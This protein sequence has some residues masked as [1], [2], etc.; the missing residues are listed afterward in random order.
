MERMECFHVDR[1]YFE[2]T[3]D[4]TVQNLILVSE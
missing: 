4:D 2:L 3:E 1:Y